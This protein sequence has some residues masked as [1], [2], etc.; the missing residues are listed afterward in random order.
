[1]HVHRLLYMIGVLRDTILGDVD[2]EVYASRLPALQPWGYRR[3]PN[4]L[5][6][7]PIL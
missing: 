6:C 2:P 7:K 5:L 4:D 3:W 1:M